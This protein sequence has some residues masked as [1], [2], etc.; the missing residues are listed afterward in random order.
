METV[1]ACSPEMEQKGLISLRRGVAPYL[2]KENL[3]KKTSVK[4]GTILQVSS[5][6]RLVCPAKISILE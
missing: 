1:I 2:G 4:L 3:V 6:K 5:P